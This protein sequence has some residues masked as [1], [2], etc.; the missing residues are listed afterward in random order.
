MYQAWDTL[1]LHLLNLT[2]LYLKKLRLRQAFYPKSSCLDLVLFDSK[3]SLFFL[4]FFFFF[5]FFGFPLHIEFIGPVSYLS[6][7]CHLGHSYSNTGSLTH[8]AGPGIEPTSQ[9]S[10]D[11]TDP[12]APQ[13]ELPVCIFYA[14][15][16]LRLT[17]PQF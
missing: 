11:T 5:F 6:H 8:C 10:Q 3:S 15:T 14:T 13:Q 16:M 4:F 9:C 17:E 12:I 2:I 1:Y 7:S